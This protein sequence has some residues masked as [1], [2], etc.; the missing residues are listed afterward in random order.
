MEMEQWDQEFI[1]LEEPG[2][3]VFAKNGRGEMKFGAVS[4]QLD[5]DK[6][7]KG[8][9]AFSFDGFDEMDEVS[10]RGWVKVLENKL[11][12]QIKFHQ[13]EKSE[14]TAETWQDA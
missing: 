2:F 12:G 13:G 3:I 11:V 8:R 14:F 6:E 9:I 7:D 10:G 5:W 1:D 4:L